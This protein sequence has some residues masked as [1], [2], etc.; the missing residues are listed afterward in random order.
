M[1]YIIK[2][3]QFNLIWEP[4]KSSLSDYFTKDHPSWHH[5]K[6]IYK[7]IKSLSTE[8]R[9]IAHTQIN[10]LLHTMSQHVRVC[11][12]SCI[13]NI[14]EIT[15]SILTERKIIAFAFVTDMNIGGYD[16]LI[17]ILARSTL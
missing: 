6:V 2:Q 11:Q 3:K 14:T 9:S 5:I 16:K 13:P 8:L 7:Y 12:L 10:G 17:I 15:K 1:K 4:E